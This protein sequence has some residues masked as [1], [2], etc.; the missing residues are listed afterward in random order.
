[1][2]IKRDCIV[3]KSLAVRIVDKSLAVR[4]VDKSLAV[5]LSLYLIV[6]PKGGFPVIARIDGQPVSKK[7]TVD[8][9]FCYKQAT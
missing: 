2:K 4:I 8:G 9:I 7:V 3:D 6:M 5:R 1:L